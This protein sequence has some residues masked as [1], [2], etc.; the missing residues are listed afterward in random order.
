MMEEK[1]C[2]KDQIILKEDIDP[3]DYIYLVKKGEFKSFKKM[4]F[5]KNWNFFHRL[6]LIGIGV[7]T[8]AVSTLTAGLVVHFFASILHLKSYYYNNII[9]IF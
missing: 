9:L 4:F 3:S 5:P 7:P 1:I 6:L 2:P 8:V